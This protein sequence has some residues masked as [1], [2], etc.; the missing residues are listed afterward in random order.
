MKSGEPSYK[1]KYFEECEEALLKIAVANYG[2]KV[3]EELKKEKLKA[4]KDKAYEITEASRA[5]FEKNLKEQMKEAR[6]RK[7]NEKWYF[8]DSKI[9]QKKMILVASLFFVFL[10]TVTTT[11]AF[12][13]NIVNVVMTIFDDY[14]KFVNDES[15]MVEGANIK[16][17]KE[18][19]GVYYPHYIPEGYKIVESKQTKMSYI[20][21]QNEVGNKLLYTIDVYLEETYLDTENVD[22]EC[23]KIDAMEGRLYKKG[24][25]QAILFHNNEYIFHISGQL[26]EKELLRVAK[27][28]RKS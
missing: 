22:Y 20:A 8:Q 18:W 10:G 26:E 1:T 14:S 3:G 2:E 25:K 16:M 21:Y 28:V 5:L 9:K 11:E 12:R 19:E 27:S 7:Q 4:Q 13:L 6:R 24:N 15:G 23:T 17:P